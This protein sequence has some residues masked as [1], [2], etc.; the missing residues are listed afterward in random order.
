MVATCSAF[1][2]EPVE[3]D[4][5]IGD[6]GSSQ[7]SSGNGAVTLSDEEGESPTG[8][9]NSWAITFTVSALNL[10]SPNAYKPVISCGYSASTAKGLTFGVKGD[11]NGYTLSLCTAS[12]DELSGSLAL[13][14]DETY[15]FAYN[16][17]TNTAYAGLAGGG[18][19][20]NMI[21]CVVSNDM[22]KTLT[23]GTSRAWTGGGTFTTT[24][25]SGYDMTALSETEFANVMSNLAISG[26]VST[27]APAVPE[28]A[29]ATLSLLALAGLCARRRR[30]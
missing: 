20:D 6:T 9:L 12:G 13:T 5:T 19:L 14:V 23:S 4:A 17:T 8:A 24:L 29:T 18:S 28:P 7:I 27:A 21:S 15:F 26:V 30:K 25:V 16:S 1:A 3:Y 11:T 2:A 22:V 10:S